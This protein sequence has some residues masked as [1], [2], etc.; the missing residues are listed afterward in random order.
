MGRRG[1]RQSPVACARW[2]RAGGGRLR[3]RPRRRRG[4][5]DPWRTRVRRRLAR[6]DASSEVSVARCALPRQ[7]WRGRAELR[8]VGWARWAR[9][10]RLPGGGSP[11]RGRRV[12]IRC[13]AQQRDSGRAARCRRLR[14]A[15]R[16]TASWL[17]SAPFRARA[18]RCVP[19]STTLGLESTSRSA[20]PP[21]C[22]AR[23]TAPWLLHARAASCPRSSP[24]QRGRCPGPRSCRAPQPTASSFPSAPLLHARTRSAC[25][26]LRWAAWCGRPR[27]PRH[28]R[29]SR[30]G[31][32]RGLASQWPSSPMTQPALRPGWPVPSRARA[33]PSGTSDRGSAPSRN[34]RT[35][36]A[37]GLCAPHAPF[38]C[39][40]VGSRRRGP[41]S[42]PP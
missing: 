17:P 34:P 33:R 3:A 1:D 8:V 25:R 36:P 13:S 4:G 40:P 15:P 28:A 37:P 23:P 12:G 35:R 30:C 32:R 16:S 11:A 19:S 29:V 27:S 41:S 31:Q 22:H 6:D 18:P 7:E 10:G 24:V 42:V 20:G 5:H 39:D 38:P 9:A 26:Q 21:R 14:R 2:T